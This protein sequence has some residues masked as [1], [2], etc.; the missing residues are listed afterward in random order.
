MRSARA[1]RALLSAAASFTDESYMKYIAAIRRSTPITVFFLSIFAVVRAGSARS[2]VSIKN[3]IRFFLRKDSGQSIFF[4][5]LSR[6]RGDFPRGLNR[7]KARA[8]L[9]EV[10]ADFGASCGGS[11]RASQPLAAALIHAAA[12]G[13]GVYS[14]QSPQG[15]LFGDGVDSPAAEGIAP[16]YSEKRHQAPF[17]RAVLLY[18]VERVVGASGI[19][20]AAGARKR[21]QKR[22]DGDLVK[23]DAKPRAGRRHSARD[24]PLLRVFLKSW[25]RAF[26]RAPVGRL[27]RILP[28][29]R[30]NRT[31]PS[32]GA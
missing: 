16:E 13:R 3:C 23:P 5:P 28:R 12:R 6:A 19:K 25:H 26:A 7:G 8:V 17:Q 20:P 4:S 31:F 10:L 11:C 24:F 29:A 32:R 21:V 27:L 9:Q 30:G 22:R 14:E 15:K 2:F 1:A 18:C